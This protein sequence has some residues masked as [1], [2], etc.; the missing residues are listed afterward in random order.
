MLTEVLT[1]ENPRKNWKT[2]N[3]RRRKEL[4]GLLE[5]GVL[6]VVYH[7]YLPCDETLLVSHFVLSI[8]QS[9]TNY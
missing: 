4:F 9:Q 8:K 3:I 1:P 5:R 6:D 7:D 2:F